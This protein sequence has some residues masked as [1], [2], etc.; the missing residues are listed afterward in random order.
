MPNLNAKHDRKFCLTGGA[1]GRGDG[2]WE[3]RFRPQ[4]A[5]LHPSVGRGRRILKREALCR[6]LPS[7]F[8]RLEAVWARFQE[9]CGGS[10]GSNLKVSPLP[11]VLLIFGLFFYRFLVWFVGRFFNWFLVL[12]WSGRRPFCGGVRGAAAPPGKH[13]HYC[14]TGVYS[15]Y[16]KSLKIN[17]W[18]YENSWKSKIPHRFWLIFIDC[19]LFSLIFHWFLLNSQYFAIPTI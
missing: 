7:R 15:T 18:I 17:D 19:Q 14:A 10:G 16:E 13:T 5:P 8:W 3:R 12:F 4:L 1:G 11:P 2:L 6:Q 9:V